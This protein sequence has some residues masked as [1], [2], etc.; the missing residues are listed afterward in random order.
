MAVGE[1]FSIRWR[2]DA[3]FEQFELGFLKECNIDHEMSLFV[4]MVVVF[5]KFMSMHPS[6]DRA[7]VLH[8]LIQLS[9][10]MRI[11]T[12]RSAGR[13]KELTAL[14]MDLNWLTNEE[15]ERWIR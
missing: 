3:N 2:C 5:R 7:G 4:K 10:K 1:V 9:A 8:G 14:G 12:L 15:L 6:E 13:I 11:T